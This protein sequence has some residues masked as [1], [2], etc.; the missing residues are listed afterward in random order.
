MARNGGLCRMLS[1]RGYRQTGAMFCTAFLELY[2]ARDARQNCRLKDCET[3]ETCGAITEEPVRT[4]VRI[5]RDEAKRSVD[6]VIS[7]RAERGSGHASG[8]RVRA[9]EA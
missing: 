4:D 6:A 1:G 8:G 5:G 7:R 2:L 9:A 3:A